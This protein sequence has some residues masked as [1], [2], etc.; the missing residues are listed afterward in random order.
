MFAALHHPQH[1]LKGE[2]LDQYLLM[3]WF[4]MGQTI[5][6]TNFLKYNGQIFGA[7]WLRIDLKTFLPSKTQQKLTKLNAKFRVEIKPLKDLTPEH[8]I[9]Y[10]KYRTHVSFD[11]PPSL[12]HVLFEDSINDFFESHQVCIYDKNKLIA[13]GIFD[14]GQDASMGITC[15]YDPDYQ[16]YSLGKYLMLQKINFSKQQGM[17]YFYPGY[18]A[19]NHSV[20]D[21]KLEL[22]KTSLEF[23]EIKNNQ[24]KPFE[25][26]DCTD[27][28]LAE[29]TQK[30]E[31]LSVCLSQR[32]FE[33][34]VLKYEY[35]DTELNEPMRGAGLLDFPIFLFCFE[36]NTNNSNPVI[37][38]DIISRQY[39]LVICD[40]AYTLNNQE[41]RN[42]Y[43]TQNLLI[44]SQHLFAT[45][46]AEA[47]ALVASRSL[48]K[49]AG[50]VNN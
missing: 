33:H 12:H 34:S 1:T 19:P 38:Y 9:L 20:F 27:T 13:C 49:V 35:F 24:W 30:L 11:A 10:N 2:S 48:L 50:L 32:N 37:I 23:F 8:L 41:F 14:L 5:F 42:D 29:M 45:E 15:F 36:R 16:K 44:M 28:P 22:S 17:S 4:R 6:T 3:G 46:S 47:M 39:H 7:I 31:E 25:E 18:F 43:Y 26:Y 40:V 21:Y